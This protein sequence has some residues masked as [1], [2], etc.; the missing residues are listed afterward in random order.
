V[1]SCLRPSVASALA[2][3]LN[4]GRQEPAQRSR[5]ASRLEAWGDEFAATNWIEGAIGNGPYQ[6]L[7]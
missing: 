6:Q 5:M 2:G 4:A 1:R 3:A 7:V